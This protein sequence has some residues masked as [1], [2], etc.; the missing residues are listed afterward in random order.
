M[1]IQLF[2]RSICTHDPSTN[3]AVSSIQLQCRFN[4]SIIRSIPTYIAFIYSIDQSILISFIYSID[5]KKGLH[6]P[7]LGVPAVAEEETGVDGGGGAG[8]GWRRKRR[9]CRRRLASTMAVAI[10][11]VESGGDLECFGMQSKITWGGLLFIDS[12]ILEAILD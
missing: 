2:N 3:I 11:G 10:G 5:Q 1:Q 9:W 8:G 12:K 6:E 4:Y 7:Y